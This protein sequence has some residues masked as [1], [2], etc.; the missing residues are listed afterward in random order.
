MK[1]KDRVAIITG[2]G[3]GIGAAAARLLAAEGAA[4]CVFGRRSEP[5]NATVEAIRAAGGTAMAVP[6]SVAAAADCQ[7]LVDETLAAWGRV[8]IFVASAG[9]ATLM[10]F[11][12]TTDE[13]WDSIIDTNLKGTFLAMR[14]VL[15]VMVRQGAGVLIAVSS[16]LGQVGLKGAAAYCASK[17]GVDQLMRA[18]AL[19]YADRG[20][21]ANVV[22]PGWVETPMT[23]SV[24][25]HP[26]L[27]ESLRSRHPAGRFGT[28]EEVAHA[29]LYLASDDA[30]WVTGSV[31][32]I[33][34]GWTAQ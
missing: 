6:G 27:F 21:R 28:P 9:T 23:E 1:L 12:E 26:A 10:K 5:L 16:I 7:R 15:P 25:A 11:T 22:A 31:L 17:G 2:G 20:I 33:D 19:E 24:Q 8:D 30:R 13:L 3:T 29:I 32:T 34:G 4:V 18:V 14:A